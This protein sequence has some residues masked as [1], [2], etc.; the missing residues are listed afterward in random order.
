MLAHD[1]VKD[2]DKSVRLMN[3]SMTNVQAN[4]AIR[5]KVE[6]NV[7]QE[8][9]GFLGYAGGS[10]SRAAD[11]SVVLII[12]TTAGAVIGAVAGFIRFNKNQM[13]HPE[14]RPSAIR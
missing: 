4:T 8:N 1:L 6:A 3:L 9:R 14:E 5:Q 12:G 11:G 7:K 10:G 13:I 2:V